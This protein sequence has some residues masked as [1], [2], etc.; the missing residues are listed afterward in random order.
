M[1]ILRL[2][3]HFYFPPGIV[4]SWHVPLD[5]IGGMQT[6]IYRLSDALSQKSVKQT[7]LTIGMKG[8]PKSWNLNERVEIQA[9]NIPMIPVR[10]KVRGT[11]GLNFYW[12]VG[13]IGRLAGSALKSLFSKKT[14]FDIIHSHCSGVAAP[15]IVGLFSKWIMRKP[16]V[17]TVH[18]CRM[19]TY[20]P[21]NK[22]DKLINR[23]IIKIEGICLSSADAVIVL[24]DR[25]KRL[26]I[27]EYK[28]LSSKPIFVVPDMIAM[29]DFPGNVTEEKVQGFYKR[30]KIPEGKRVVGF[31]GRIAHEKGWNYLVEA[32]K[33]INTPNVHFLF[34]GDGNEREQLDEMIESLGLRDRVTVTGFISNDMVAVGISISDVMVIPSVHEELGSVLLEVA[35]LKKPVIAAAVGG[36]TENIKDGYSGIL[37]P[38]KSP[39]AIAEKLDCL[40]KDKETGKALGVNLYSEIKERFDQSKV[41]EKVFSCYEKIKGI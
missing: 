39:A 6:Q 14:R 25:T 26:L 23:Y 27:N 15:L 31:A 37:V 5:P 1:N 24:T 28:K 22:L 41:M 8:A 11:V 18:C 12:G 34:C 3:P 29:D 35:S 19:G 40:L 21:M 16:L 33:L 32:I 36:L 20:E 38:S 4:E 9:A 17:Y 30:F 7:V 2:T 13:V 10:S